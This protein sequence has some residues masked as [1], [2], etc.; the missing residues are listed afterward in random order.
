MRR[1]GFLCAV[2]LSI[3]V[4]NL[5]G[6]ALI[7][8]PY[9][10]YGLGDIAQ[11][12]S[13]FNWSLGGTGI[14]LRDGLSLNNINPASYTAI[15]APFTQL[16]D[17]SFNISVANQSDRNN[18]DP[19]VYGNFSGAGFWFRLNQNMGLT[20]GLAPFSHVRYNIQEEKTFSGIEGDYVANYQ[21]DGGLNQ[22]YVGG[23]YELFGHLSLGMHASYVFGNLSHNQYVTSNDVDYNVTIEKI[24]KLNTFYLDYG[25]QYWFNLNNEKIVLGATFSNERT[26]GGT[27]DL[28]VYQSADTLQE[29]TTPSGEYLLPLSY[30]GGISWTHNN[31]WT[32][33][34]DYSY[35]K[36][37][38][39]TFE[40][41]FRVRD[42]QRFSAGIAF[43]PN[44][45][46]FSYIKRMGLNIGG[47]FKNTYLELDDQGIDQYGV[48]A[49]I[50]LPTSGTA[51]INFIYER[52]FRGTDTSN[53]IN[54][55][56]H[57]I[58]FNLSFFDVWFRK[59]KF[60]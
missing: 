38:D 1:S 13:G 16:A 23:A 46:S 60:Q 21:G 17:F 54:E 39:A 45:N 4:T 3:G 10:I 27:Y 7:D 32:I 59:S 55:N 44:L 58:T 35:Q 28:N 36:W 14:A 12:G 24:L 9:T 2:F 19:N 42:T 56:F 25:L 41:G 37:S 11:K 52:S 5:F 50:T 18:S 57:H 15:K 49:G 20:I 47:Y 26:F 6:Q 8:S 31:K 43:L 40:D 30:G 33:T 53:L 29:S 34:S 48:T 22:V 51:I